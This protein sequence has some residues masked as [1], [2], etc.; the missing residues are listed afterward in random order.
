VEEFE[1]TLNFL[2]SDDVK[3][4]KIQKGLKISS[5]IYESVFSANNVKLII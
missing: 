1:I 3:N 2:Q 5:T 4:C